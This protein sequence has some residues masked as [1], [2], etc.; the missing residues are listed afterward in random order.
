MAKAD[1]SRGHGVKALQ[2]VSVNIIRGLYVLRFS[3]A[4]V[5]RYCAGD[6]VARKQAVWGGSFGWESAA[7]W[8][9]VW[10][11]PHARIHAN[12]SSISVRLGHQSDSSSN[13]PNLIICESL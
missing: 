13:Y 11:T 7:T 10:P 2:L 6:I 12:A 5:S 9:A 1:L 8:R 4:M 3:L